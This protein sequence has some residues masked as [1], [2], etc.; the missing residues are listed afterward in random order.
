ME[1]PK[2]AERMAEELERQDRKYGG[3]IMGCNWR[4]ECCSHC[5]MINEYFTAPL[6]RMMPKRRSVST[7]SPK[8]VIFIFATPT[9]PNFV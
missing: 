5:P 8:P 4:V 7:G 6:S 2:A 1:Y 3:V 9:P